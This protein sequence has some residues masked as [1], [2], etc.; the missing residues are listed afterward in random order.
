MVAK[1]IAS[2]LIAVSFGA[3]SG[4]DVK[5][6]KPDVNDTFEVKTKDGTTRL[7]WASDTLGVWITIRCMEA[8]DAKQ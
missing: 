2:A 1:M 6:F 7:C 5:V 4:D 3:V 8:K